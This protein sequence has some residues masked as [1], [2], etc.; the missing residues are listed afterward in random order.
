MKMHSGRLRHWIHRERIR[1]VI[2][3]VFAVTVL[4][5]CSRSQEA[6]GEPDADGDQAVEFGEAD[7]PCESAVLTNDVGDEK[8]LRRAVDC[9]FGEVEAGN[10]VTIDID[11]PTVEGDSIFLRYGYDGDTF[12]LVQDSRLDSFGSGGVDAQRC[13]ELRPTPLLPEGIDC[14]PV[15]HQGFTEAG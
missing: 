9:F 5:A 12:L 6:V 1:G 13:A 3:L 14:R 15:E 8:A 4:T 11:Q 2:G 10:A 7:G